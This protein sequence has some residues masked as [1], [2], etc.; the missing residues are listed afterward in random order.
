MRLVGARVER[1]EDQRILT[2]RGH[3][4]DDLQLPGM[5]HAAFLR[6]PYAHAHIT[7]IDAGAALNAAGVVAVYTGR[8]LRPLSKPIKSTLPLGDYPEA[9]PLVIDKVLYVG[10]LVA[11]VVAESRYLAE[12]A[13]ELID[14]QY[15]PLP[16]VMDYESALDPSI[17]PLSSSRRQEPR[18]GKL[19]SSG[20][21]WPGGNVAPGHCTPI[22]PDFDY[23]IID[24]PSAL[25]LLTLN[26]LVAR[27]PSSSR[28]SVNF[29]PLKAFPSD[30]HD[31]SGAGRIWINSVTD[32]RNSLNDVR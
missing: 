7:S 27:I 2:G 5:L 8:D 24:C 13:L 30:G 10:D 21:G 23:I 18:S 25:D 6:S 3:Y 28:S 32:R 1:V 15:E 17:P 29:L 11:M 12:D 4:I 14:V 9:Y 31:R 22:R 19:G 26:A 20:D 16:P